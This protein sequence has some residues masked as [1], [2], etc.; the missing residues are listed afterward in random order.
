M[1]KNN[2]LSVAAGALLH[3][4]RPGHI[5][6]GSST[7]FDVCRRIPS[8]FLHPEPCIHPASGGCDLLASSTGQMHLTPPM[9]DARAPIQHLADASR[10]PCK[11]PARS[12][13]LHC[14]GLL[15]GSPLITEYSPL[16][17]RG[18]G[19]SAPP[20]R[21]AAHGSKDHPTPLPPWPRLGHERKLGKR[22]LARSASANPS[23]CCP[24]R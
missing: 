10:T 24:R 16:I 13:G 4:Q 6:D 14:G 11:V 22:K 5:L 3:W 2:G 18:R 8:F 23:P 1:A 7:R 9:Q 17:P 21:G 15:L 20:Q 12:C 19:P